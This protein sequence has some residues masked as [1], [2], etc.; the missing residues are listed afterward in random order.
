M[1]IPDQAG[2]MA[3]MWRAR[4]AG[5]VSDR[6]IDLTRSRGPVTITRGRGSLRAG[7]GRLSGPLDRLV[8]VLSRRNAE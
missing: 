5:R 3:G 6:P 7:Q 4:P 2:G 8:A 1:V